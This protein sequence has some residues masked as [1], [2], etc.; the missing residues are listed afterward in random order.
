MNPGYQ[1]SADFSPEIPISDCTLHSA[2]RGE[3]TVFK[4]SNCS[5]VLPK[6]HIEGLPSD[7]DTLISKFL[8]SVMLKPLGTTRNRC[9]ISI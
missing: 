5:H 2:W 1:T 9:S 7:A 8:P 4:H 6:M 3:N